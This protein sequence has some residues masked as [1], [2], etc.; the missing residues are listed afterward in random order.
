MIG[1]KEKF[2]NN[3]FIL[4]NEFFS[5]SKQN[6]KEQERSFYKNLNE[7]INQEEKNLTLQ[8]F[9]EKKAYL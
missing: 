6:Q 2:F 7:K 8:Q 9:Y 3:I 1:K 5:L 4:I